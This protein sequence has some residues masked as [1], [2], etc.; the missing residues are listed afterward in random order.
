M[1]GTATS[2]SDYRVFGLH[3]RSS[4]PLP[5]LHPETVPGDADVTVSL[6]PVPE[7]AG[8]E[9]GLTSVNG[10]LLLVVPDVGRYRIE[11]GRRITV[12]PVPNVPERNLRL[13]LLGSALA[14]SGSR[15]R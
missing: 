11:C 15:P 14:W 5:E 12:E 4:V 2:S 9:P 1:K 8:L 7:A 6:G 13:F 10:T 3:V